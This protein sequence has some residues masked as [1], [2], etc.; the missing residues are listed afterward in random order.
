[1]T[2]RVCTNLLWFRNFEFHYRLYLGVCA[3]RDLCGYIKFHTILT[4]KYATWCFNWKCLDLWFII[5][6]IVKEPKTASYRL[7]YIWTDCSK[8]IE[9]YFIQH[10]YN[11]KRN[12]DEHH[13]YLLW[14]YKKKSLLEWW[15]SS[16]WIISEKC[17]FTIIML[18]KL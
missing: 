4:N 13:L 5:S 9:I 14:K 15:C 6:V 17:L 12:H 10:R 18:Y 11:K 8:Q 2:N 16:N 7:K 1:M 3:A